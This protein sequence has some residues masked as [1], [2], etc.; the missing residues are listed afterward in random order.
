MPFT[1]PVSP[2]TAGRR[3]AVVAPGHGSS[4]PLRPPGGVTIPAA[5]S[6]AAGIG[7]TN[8]STAREARRATT[9]AATAEVRASRVAADESDV[10]EVSKPNGIGAIT[11]TS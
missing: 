8:G 4:G 7:I 1:L 10:S 6:Y 3:A 2:Q 11:P 5:V 9:P